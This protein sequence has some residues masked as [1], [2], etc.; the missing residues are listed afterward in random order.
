MSDYKKLFSSKIKSIRDKINEYEKA[1]N[2]FKDYETASL[3]FNRQIQKN[4]VNPEQDP[5]KR[6]NCVI[7]TNLWWH[8]LS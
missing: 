2:F 1:S 7:Q 6:K 8:T 5:V 3:Q 4:I